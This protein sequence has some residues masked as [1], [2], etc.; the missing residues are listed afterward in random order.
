MLGACFR[1]G[2][3]NDLSAP[4]YVSV[5]VL[6]T[7]IRRP[8]LWS[9]FCC[10]FVCRGLFPVISGSLSPRHGASSSCGWRNG[11]QYGG[12][13][14]IYWI[15]SR[16][17]PTRGG[18]P[19]WGLGEELTTP[20]RKNETCYEI[21]EQKASYRHWYF[22]QDRDRWRALVN[23]VMNLRVFIKW[24]GGG[25]SWVVENRLASQEGLCSMV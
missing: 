21:F 22:A 12:Q 2:R 19:A 15:S 17:Q 9:I 10:T 5:K 24:G 6:H 7:K 16:G 8:C 25:I 1:P 20:H 23:A 13:L 18:L 3:P 4:L 11:L 14:R